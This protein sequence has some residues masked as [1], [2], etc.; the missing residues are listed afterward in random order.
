MAGIWGYYLML[1]KFPFNLLPAAGDRPLLECSLKALDGA[2]PN[3]SKELASL[4]MV[5]SW[6]V[7]KERNNRT[8][9]NRTTNFLKVAEKIVNELSY[10]RLAGFRGVQWTCVD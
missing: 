3:R 5:V 1:Y 10:W 7:W 9:N 8:F 6:H 2:A 4:L